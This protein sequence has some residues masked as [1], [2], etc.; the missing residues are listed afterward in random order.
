MK[1][2]PEYLTV[3]DLAEALQV[4]EDTVRAMLARGELP[5]VQLG[6]RWYVRRAAFDALFA[7]AERGI[8]LGSLLP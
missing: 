1:P 2:R 4:H 8:D 3:A 6:R 7:K 5:G